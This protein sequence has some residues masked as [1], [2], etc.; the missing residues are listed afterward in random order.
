MYLKTRTWM[1]ISL[2]LL[3]ASVFFWLYGNHYQA[4]KK[5]T[6][7]ANSEAS[8][9]N[10]PSAS[11]R[12]SSSLYPL[13]TQLDHGALS[14]GREERRNQSASEGDLASKSDDP[15][16]YRLRNT[17]RP[18]RELMR[19]ESALLLRN[20][21]I[22]TAQSLDLEIPE[23]L[24]SDGEPGSYIVQTRG[25]L[26][27]E[28]R[29][30]L[31]EVD[32]EIISYVPNNAYL[33]KMSAESSRKLAGQNG[34]RTLLPF[35]PYYKLDTPLLA[36]A[37]EQE[38]IPEEFLLRLTLLPGDRA[39]A[40]E[41]IKLLNAE[42]IGEEPSPFGPQVVIRPR[43]DSLSQLARLATVQGI[44][45]VRQRK[46]ATDRTRI[47][48][49][50]STNGTVPGNYLGLTG[51][52]M[53]VNIN[54]TGVDETHPDFEGRLFAT[55]PK[56]LTDI[57]GHGTHVAGIIA[58]NGSQ[59]VGVGVTPNGSETNANYRG[60]APEVRL[61]VQATDYTPGVSIPVTDTYITE[62]AARTN[63]RA[64]GRGNATLI[65]NN[66]WFYGGATDYDSAAARYDAAARD[67]LPDEAGSQPILFV[68]TA[69]N[70]GDGTDDG[71]NGNPN[72]IPSPGSAKNVITVGASENFRNVTN[73]VVITNAEPTLSVTNT[74]F[75]AQT[76]SLDQ[77]A[78]FSGR[79]NV[80]IG[81]EGQFGR[82]KPDIVAPGSYIISTR[83]KDWRLENQVN[84]DEPDTRVIET[85]NEELGTSYRYESGTSMAA[86]AVSGV[87]SLMQEFFESSLPPNRRRTNSPAMMKALLINGARS[88]GNRYDLQVENTINLQGWG[89]MNLTN[90]IPAMLATEAEDQWPIRFFDQ[91]VEN[92]VSTGQT[93]SWEV[94]LST[95]AQQLGF[96]V[97]L[98]WTDPPGNP[99]TAIKLVNDL[100][101]V[102]S[103]TVSHQVYYGNDIGQ[104]SDF[105]QAHMTNSPP[106][107]DIINNVE[108]VFLRDAFGSNFVVSVVGKRVNV[109]SV[110]GFHEATGLDNDVVQDYALVMSIGDLTLTNELS[111]TPF[112]DNAPV[113]LPLATVMTNGLPLLN[114]R[115][116]AQPMLLDS[117]YGVAE[118]WNFFVFTNTFITNSF[119]TLTNGTN[120]AFIT[121]LPPNL[122]KSRNLESDIDL[123]VSNDPGLRDLDQSV[124]DNAWK[125]TGRG[126]TELVVFT[127]AVLDEV[128]YIGVRAEDQQAGEFGLIGISSDDP[129]E[130]NVDGNPVLQGFP[131]RAIIPDGTANLP[132]SVQVFAVG[133]SPNTV[134]RVTVSSLITHSNLGDLIGTLSH[135][136]VSAVLNNHT[137]GNFTGTNFFHYNDSFS[138]GIIGS[139]RTDGPGSLEDFIGSQSSGVWM[140]N[141]VDNS[142]SHTGRVENLSLT[143]QPF[144]HGNLSDAG[145][146]GIAGSVGPNDSVCFFD[147]VPP[148]ATNLVVR[149][150]QM[151]GPLDVLI[152]REANP[153][154]E[155]FDK[156]ATISPPGGDLILGLDDQPLP[157]LAG[158]YFICLFNTNTTEV[159]DFRVAA[160]H[161][162]GPPVDSSLTLTETNLF[163]LM[164]DS[165]TSTTFDVFAD[166]IL[167]DVQVGLR[168]NHPRAADLTAHLVSPQ[169]TRI[170]LTENRGG[171][172]F[173]GYGGGFGTN[174]S[175]SIFTEQTNLFE[176]LA[177]IKFSSPPF[178]NTLDDPSVE[179]FADSFE[180]SLPGEFL[181]NSIVSGWT[182][183]RGRAQ[184]HGPDSDFGLT[185]N[186]GTNFL[187]LDTIQ[188]PA[189]I[190]RTFDTDPGTL[191]MLNLAF[192]RS[193]DTQPGL[194]H[195]M[196]V[197]YG[198]PA[199][200]RPANKFIPAILPAW[201]ETNI[202]FQATEA[203][204]MLEL[205]ALTSSGPLVDS[206]RVTDIPI[207]TNNFVFPEEALDLLRGERTIGEW[208]LEVTDSRGGP[209]G[210][211]EPAL[212][213]WELAM[214]YGNPRSPAVFLTNGIPFS[215]VLTND[216]TNYFIVDVC[217]TTGVAFA[218]LTGPESALGLLADHAGLPT[219]NPETDD[220]R[221]M[222][223]S[224]V[225]EVPPVEEPPADAPPTDEPPVEDPATDEPPTDEPPAAADPPADDPPAEVASVDEPPVGEEPPIDGEPPADGEPPVDE[226]PPEPPLGAVSFRLD[227]APGHP[228]PLRP[229]KRFFLAVHNLTGDETNAYTIQLNFDRDDCHGDDQIIRLTSGIPFTN[230]IPE[231]PGLFNYYI[232]TASCAVGTVEFELS[233]N[234]GDLGMVLRKGPQ[235]PLPDLTEFDFFSDEPGLTNELILVTTNSVPVPVEPGD[236]WFV[237]VYSNT[238][239]PVAYNIRATEF[240]DE[241]LSVSGT[242]VVTLTNSV[243]LDFSILYCPQFT[244]YFKFSI[245]NEAPG[246]RFLASNLS[247]DT[248]L[249]VGFNEPP[250]REMFFRSNSVVGGFSVASSIRP[251][252]ELSSVKGDWYVYV[253]SRNP[254][255]LDFTILA[256]LLDPAPTTD[257]VYIDPHLTLGLTELCLTWDS[258]IDSQYQVEAKSAIE[259]GWQAISPAF[260]A[261]ES[262]SGFCLDLPTD[263][264]FFRIVQFPTALPPSPPASGFIDPELVVSETDLCLRWESTLGANYVVQAKADIEETEWTQITA[265]IP[266]TGATAEHCVTF[267]TPFS[268]F[269]IAIVG[270]DV[271]PPEPPPPPP[272]ASGFVDPEV[273][274]SETDVCLQWASDLGVNYVVEA[275]AEIGEIEWTRITGLIPG[276]GATAEHCEAK[277]SPY[278]FFRIAIVGG[279]VEPPPPPPPASG[280][281]D[282]EVV[283][284]E[285]DVCL[286]WASDLGVNYVVEAK[287]EIGEIEWTRITGLI[288]GTGATAEHCEARTSPYRF[289]RIAIVG[290]EVEP[291]PPPPPPASGFIDPEVVLSET[292]LCL[293]WASELGVNYVVEAKAEIGAAEWIRIT[294]LIPG[295]GATAEHCEAKTSIYRF[296]R[297]A[298]VGGDVEPP[299]PPPP[300]S[301]FIDPEVV[302]GETDV[303]LQWASDL[304]VN[305]VV[306]AKVEIG[307]IEW[308]RITDLI[309]GTGAAA[310]HC[311][312]RTSTYRFFRIAI[313]GGEVEPPPPTGDTVQL[314]AP[315]VSIEG[316]LRFTWSSSPGTAYQ[317][318]WTTDLGSQPDV[319]W[320]T[321]TNLTA[322]GASI[323]VSDPTPA[324]N[325]V[326]FY[327]LRIP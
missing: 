259:V 307:G 245:P 216:Q 48:L 149:L 107:S 80:G 123:Y 87:L 197:Y 145:P 122:A 25:P 283:L 164:D 326:R 39:P 30:T 85:L 18:V 258:L 168:I 288:P 224:V 277:T 192:H 178:T 175:H 165:V 229:G 19:S 312:A 219:A 98:V 200:F 293:Q 250:S 193:P 132:G 181:S 242:N 217:D 188:S 79:G 51:K 198:P 244:N 106:V 55:D 246:V 252:A 235:P 327:R 156:M 262:E 152:R 67:A 8:E 295:T 108:N 97:S 110:T 88:L 272:P 202:V 291:P 284:G 63:S 2:F 282:P 319:T 248:D 32:A 183:S 116:G 189:S 162:L 75:L 227:T 1:L 190:L 94:N 40:L 299:P 84:F 33:V 220:F 141:M 311:E 194:P 77:I 6:A 322:T 243:P 35:E 139:Q 279:E 11:S 71:M 303:C 157:L 133:I 305:Y 264:Q 138:G 109:S 50:V 95:N 204:T 111:V 213:S 42:L 255:N 15:V 324:T 179:I 281:I 321:L 43:S 69:S 296:F 325:E 49:G 234:N 92:A 81:T 230:S 10:A 45:I 269:Q 273:V 44:E 127:N 64:F 225:L 74:P 150:S 29:S 100:D 191:Y 90:S 208:T 316:I 172:T 300:A 120:V 151:T 206:V 53:V 101:L 267:P 289:F 57:V 318:Q 167:T 121:F 59:S 207:T 56:L 187:E 124:L 16:P 161:G 93:K 24:R 12:K 308:T 129:F 23:H 176:D 309:P 28:I 78:P 159:V 173:Q 153:T 249:F 247:D 260:T 278:R 117:R 251:N 13:L 105:N 76:D 310:E 209:I 21:F 66:S 9:T 96:R 180:E 118:Q 169:G 130:R 83:S 270:G 37:V 4:K 31:R 112:T 203:S 72:T 135:N 26:G 20:A 27:D 218:T 158:R 36:L 186:S 14:N 134:R 265:E 82:F 171:I 274:L 22:E 240:S 140:L 263:L 126:G 221:R 62:T 52:D 177:P 212:L 46:I 136:R 3:A 237:G 195:A 125:S 275:K 54:D 58:G 155:D 306:E 147:D 268:F 104:S 34:V 146:Q 232:Y 317:L 115:A 103:N 257:L 70:S 292:D 210:G 119:S 280:F 222:T 236:D 261:T 199:D 256:E 38:P 297:I 143:I 154:P 89:I 185:A 313:V 254:G 114:Q 65:S 323:T 298:I 113:E 7:P 102:V 231:I 184:L 99:N 238:N 211:L 5:Q 128:F 276:T 290:G 315:V 142:L 86:P 182:V 314:G 215:G 223:N 47:R 233:P 160:L 60:M 226:A 131:V 73:I 241:G 41:Q 201:A 205:S 91:E 302:L 61:F 239:G 163:R 320:T 196:Q 228:A 294:D 174:I 68:F 285:T 137:L 148:E 266:G 253:V 166:K 271:Q 301:G 214:Q 144:Q 17:S 286:Q 304:G 287:A 170:V